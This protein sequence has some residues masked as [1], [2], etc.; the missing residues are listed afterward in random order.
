[1]CA[2]DR[3]HLT[4]KLAV[5]ITRTPQPDP[6]RAASL[7]LHALSIARDTGSARI[8]RELRTLDNRLTEQWPGLPASR[9]FRDALAA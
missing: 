9:A 2:A 7:G 1:M 5:A 3:G 4:S 6:A 8:M